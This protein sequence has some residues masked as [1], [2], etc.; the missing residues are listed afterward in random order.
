MCWI[1]SNALWITSPCVLKCACAIVA[2]K[3]ID[4]TTCNTKDKDVYGLKLNPANLYT[5]RH[6]YIH[7]L[8]KINQTQAVHIIEI[9]Q[10][11]G[12]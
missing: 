4:N 2:K 12:G 1:V 11:E 3:L 9:M 7:C 6:I 10:D 5:N 8:D